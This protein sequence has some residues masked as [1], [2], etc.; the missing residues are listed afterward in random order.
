MAVV[1]LALCASACP[2][3][4]KTVVHDLARRVGVADRWSGHDVILFGTPAAEPHQVEGF[5]REG[6][7]P[8]GDGFAWSKGEA[9]LSLS[10]GRVAPR[11]AVV[12]MAP[13][14]GVKEQAAEVS[15]N[16]THVAR[17]VLND[18]RHRY[19]V[20][21]P[22]A[23]Q[24][25]GD[26]RLR[27]AFAATASPADVPGNPDRRRL[28][29]AFYAVTVGAAD[30][31]GLDDLLAREAPRPFSV[32]EQGGVPAL[33][34]MAPS[35]V[36]HA[37]RLPAGAELRFTPRL[38]SAARAAGASAFL[39]VTL[40]ARAGE[41]KELWSRAV[42]ARSGGEEDEVSLPLPG[43][44][45]D[46][47]RLGLHVGAP[48]GAR[49]AWAV[50]TAP[51]VVGRKGAVDNPLDPPPV[52]EEEHG[53][54]GELRRAL[55]DVNVLLIVLDAARAASFGAYG[56]GRRTTPEVDRIAAEGVVF[57]QA[58]TPAVYTLGAMSSLWT[59][60]YPDR[61][62]AEVSYADRLPADRLTL[63]EAL[64]EGG[65]HSAGF[66]ANPMAG[67]LFGF[68]RG[69]GEFDQVYERFEDLG[70]RAAAFRRVLPG[71]LSENA[72]RRFFAYVH[73]RE[74]HFPYDPGPPFD[75]RFGPDAPL[76]RAQR[77]D[78]TWYTDVNQGRVKPSPGE[79]AHL[80][81]LYDGN[82]AYVDREVG[83]LR[84]ALE[85]AGL[86]DRTVV[87][88]T[89]DHGEQLYEHGYISHSAQV[90]EES[91]RVP[92]IVRFPRESGPRGT[93]VA[94]HVDL[95]DVAPTVLDVF[96]LAG[97]GRAAR[98]FQGRSLLP[99]LAGAPG[100]DAVVSR[101]VWERPVYGLRE[102]RFKYI[103]DTRTGSE[104][105][106][107]LEQD[108]AES[109]PLQSAEPLRAAYHRQT[110]HDWMARLK[111]P[112]GPP[113]APGPGPG[114]SATTCEQLG[115]LGYVDARCK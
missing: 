41:E 39:R 74:P 26:N 88:V 105:L 36:R 34:Q 31:A 96:G 55:P 37:L 110:L 102:G 38:H 71:W 58:Y 9:E 75:T 114:L 40:E 43:A 94:A 81:R 87:I 2:G 33:V 3:A 18:G 63:A 13:Y 27:F 20:P 99:V 15:L 21:L 8:S 56:Y 48:P 93:R 35:V 51:R 65:V 106:F 50:W 89:A 80:I 66:I 95:L 23:A 24:R 62:H 98:E 57:E 52:S 4:Q 14:R 107:D 70:S 79:I 68:E 111:R 76:G 45:G 32:I 69:F 30:D 12:D 83:A 113:A 90:Y 11:T 73:F 5:H 59:S 25:A 84:A 61:H 22:A 78:K 86:W 112:S 115:A 1:A 82:L 16:G 54:A 17:L 104:L 92:L 97:R 19:R 6:A 53:R 49:F 42:D 28:A 108:P 85:Q 44:A 109:R 7:I 103:H 100:K 91:M 47:V 72:S 10:F 101:T 77:R 29:A 64:S 46:I 67:K 60:Q